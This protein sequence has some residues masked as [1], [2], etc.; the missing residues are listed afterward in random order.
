MEL[1][2]ASLE[3]TL[4]DALDRPDLSG[5]REEIWRSLESVEF[6]NLDKVVEYGLLL[7]NATTGAKVGFF[8]EQHRKP[9]M[10]E[11]TRRCK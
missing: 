9:L 4:V 3:R 1:R 6:F 8:L 10:E 11:G 7:G 2:I 5:S